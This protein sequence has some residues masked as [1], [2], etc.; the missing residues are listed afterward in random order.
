MVVE[1]RVVFL[2]TTGAV[3]TMEKLSPCMP[4]TAVATG[5]QSFGSVQVNATTTIPTARTQAIAP[6]PAIPI[7]RNAETDHAGAKPVFHS[8]QDPIAWFVAT[9]TRN[10]AKPKVE[11]VVRWN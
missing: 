3:S 9:T 4:W 5:E 2:P 11:S 8:V 6:L 1:E 7:E 10:S